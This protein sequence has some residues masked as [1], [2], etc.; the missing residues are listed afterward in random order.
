M[1]KFKKISASEFETS[2]F[3]QL[4]KFLFEDDYFSKM[5]TDAKVMYALLKDRFELSKIN[6]WIDEEN[7]IYL[8]YTNKQL[9]SILQYGEP[10]IIKLKKELEKFNLI[11]NERQGLNRPNKIYLL[12]PSY[13]KELTNRKF[14]N[15]QI[16]SSRTNENIVQELTIC[17]SNDTDI[18][19]TDYK[20]TENNDTYDMNESKDVINNNTLHSNHANHQFNEFN[21]NALK[22]H[23]L[24]EIPD[25][26]QSYL[27]N[28]EVSEIQIIKSVILKAKTSFNNEKNTI[29]MLEDIEFEMINVL[30]RFKATLIQKEENVEAMQGYLMRSIKSELEEIHSLNMR[31]KN[32]PQNNLFNHF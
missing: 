3:Y 4:P 21:N 15:K 23:L 1:S 7:N 6:N 20:E 17:K 5:T 27:S 32:A 14:Q 26:L 30:K 19:D 22:Y 29:Y 11:I 12:E 8:L 13:D 24:Q 25:Q 16:V 9:C 2:R 10:K 18:N 31:K 28:F